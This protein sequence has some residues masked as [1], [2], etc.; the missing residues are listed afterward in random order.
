M[1][2]I[3]RLNDEGYTLAELIIVLAI[4]VILSSAAFITLSVIHT[5]KAKD[6]ATTFYAEINALHGRAKGQQAYHDDN[7]NGTMDAGE[8]MDNTNFAL[9]LYKVGE[10]TYLKKVVRDS[11][12]IYDTNMG[13]A[14][15]GLGLNLSPYIQIKYTAD[16][17][18]YY[19]D[20]MSP[21]EMHYIA[22][23]STGSCIE[24]VGTYEFCKKNG[25]KL[26][27]VTIN[28]NGSYR[29]K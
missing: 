24:G 14:N 26:V 21:T 2:K 6:A 11:S 19:K 22:F 7:A 4:I 18:S 8:F 15:G 29:I 12:G 17:N 27:T 28:R 9:C 25:G 16:N 1:K 10:K 20:D 3:K 23:D 13:N 5:A